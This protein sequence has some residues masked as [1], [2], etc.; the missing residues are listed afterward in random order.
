MFICLYVDMFVCIHAY[1][2]VICIFTYLQACIY[3]YILIHSIHTHLHIVQEV[4]KMNDNQKQK[5]TTESFLR[6]RMQTRKAEANWVAEVC[7]S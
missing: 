7:A 3:I 6:T 2:C 1:V 5:Q 4:Q